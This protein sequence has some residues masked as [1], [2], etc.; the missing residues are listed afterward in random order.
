MKHFTTIYDVPDPNKLIAEAIQIKQNPFAFSELGKGKTIGLIFMN[1]SLRTRLSTQK[2][3]RL[4]G[5]EVMIMNLEK[6]S[7]AIEWND[8]VIMN[9]NTVE[10]IKDAAAV[11]GSYCDIIGMRCFPTLTNKQ[12]DYS[13]KILIQLMKYCNVP[14]VSLESATLHPLQSLADAVTIKENWKQNHKPKV[15][16]TWAPHIKALPQAVPNSFAE[17]MTKLDV[18]ITITHPEGYELC[19]DYTKGA[20]IEYNQEKALQDADFVYVKNW[21]AYHEYGL[22]PQVEDNWMMD[23][24]KYQ[25]TNNAG[26]MHCLPV[27]RDVELSSKLIDHPNSLIQQQAANRVYSAQAVLKNILMK[28]PASKQMS[29][30]DLSLEEA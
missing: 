13:E 17:W 20:S 26:I 18:D 7:W 30:E 12:L 8:D 29:I 5:M 16:L 24:D 25:L 10:H 15:V 3:A 2:A 28:L 23:L 4:L 9:G 1:P 14:V 21:S 27:R 6:E 11:L 19:E 22:M